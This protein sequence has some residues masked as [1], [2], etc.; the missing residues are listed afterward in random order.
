MSFRKQNYVPKNV[1]ELWISIK[2]EWLKILEN[3]FRCLVTCMLRLFAGLRPTRKD[4]IQLYLS[5]T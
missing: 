3:A 4:P 2:M 5:F 1:T